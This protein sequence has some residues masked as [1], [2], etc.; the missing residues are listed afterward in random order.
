MMGVFEASILDHQVP[1]DSTVSCS[2]VFFILYWLPMFLPEILVRL[3]HREDLLLHNSV[4]RAATVNEETY[5]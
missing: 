4:R 1:N 5:V 3:E 2:L